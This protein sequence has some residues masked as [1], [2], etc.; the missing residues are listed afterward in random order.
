METVCGFAVVRRAKQNFLDDLTPPQV[1]GVYYHGV[2]RQGWG[3]V[4]EPYYDGTLPVH[5]SKLFRSLN[6][7]SIIELTQ[8]LE[9]AQDLL[10]FSNQDEPLNEIIV[11]YSKELERTKGSFL[12]DLKIKWLG[13][14]V[15]CGGK[16][17]M[18][19]EGIFTKPYLFS[20]FTT[21][22]N[23]YGLFDINSPATDWYVVHYNELT[24]QR[25]NLEVFSDDRFKGSLYKV[26]VGIPEISPIYYN[27]QWVW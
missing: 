21:A 26:W 8:E 15:V 17:S 24:E 3:D 5:Y 13:E 14:D 12:I 25:H 4:S 20:D 23:Q 7:T 6:N 1:G 11:V 18:L 27:G 2:A 22:L 9:I 10:S 19:L 16:G